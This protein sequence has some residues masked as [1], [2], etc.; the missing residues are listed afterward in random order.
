MSS[1]PETCERIDGWAV[2]SSASVGEPLLWKLSSSAL[3]CS[4][5]F[6]FTLSSRGNW[7]GTAFFTGP[8]LGA[9][10]TSAFTSTGGGG[11]P[12]RATKRERETSETERCW[13]YLV[14]RI[15]TLRLFAS[16]SHWAAG[17]MATIS[18]SWVTVLKNCQMCFL[19][20]MMM[21][22]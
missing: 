4:D 22:S 2:P 19:Q 9:G 5:V 21:S 16:T 7:L 6:P 3:S 8:S 17:N 18:P 14:L 10:I 20:N 12:A 13:I 11:T 15:S 1:L